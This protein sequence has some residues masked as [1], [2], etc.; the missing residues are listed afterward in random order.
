MCMEPLTDALRETLDVFEGDG[1]PLTTSEVADRLELGRRSTYERLD[2]LSATDHLETKKVGASARVWW[3]P[4]GTSPGGPGTGFD[5]TSVIDNVLDGSGIGVVVLDE[6]Y[7]VA[8]VNETIERY[9]GIDAG[10]IVGRHKPDVVRSQILDR[11]A[12]PDEFAERVLPVYDGADTGLTFDC[13][14]TGVKGEGDRWLEHR[15]RPIESGTFAGGRIEFYQ[16]VTARYRV[17]RNQETSRAQFESFIEAVDEYA[18]F[19]LDVEGCVQSWN[20]GARRLKGYAADEVLGEHISTFYTEEDRAAG[21][22]ESNLEQARQDGSIQVEGWRRRSD[23]SRFWA[24]VTIRAVETDGEHSGYIKITKDTTERR[25]RERQLRRE[26]DLTHELLETAPVRLGIYRADGTLERV[27][28]MTRRRVGL[29]AESVAEFDVDDLEFYDADGEPLSTADHPVPQVLE[30]GEPAET[31]VQHDDPDGRRHWVRLSARPVFG[32]DD[33]LERVIIAGEEVTDLKE[34]EAQL[35]RQRD[36]LS[37]ELDE[38][39]ER[40]DEAFVALDDDWRFT[41]VNEAAEGLLEESAGA[42]MGQ[43]IWERFPAAHGTRFEQE[44]RRARETGESVTFEEYFAPLETWFEVSA[45]PSENGLSVYFQ[46]V[47]ERKRREEELERYETIVETMSD[48]VYVIDDD[49]TITM[50]NES[51]AELLGYAPDEVLG[52]NAADIVDADV[53]AEARRLHEELAAGECGTARLEAELTTN[54]GNEIIAEATFGLIDTGTDGHE[55]VGVVRD[56]TQRKAREQR[57]EQYETIVETI[58]DGIYAVDGA[59]RFTL[60]NHGFVRL[61]G[62]DRAE[63]LG[64][65]ASKVQEDNITV[66]AESQ[67]REIAAGEREVG[68]VEVDVVTKDGDTVPCETRF[69]LVESAPEG[70]RCG[71]VRDI[72]DRLEQEREL[73]RRLTQQEMVAELGQRALDDSDVDTLMAEATRMVADVLDTDYCKVLELAD[74]GETLR[75]RQGVGWADGVVGSAEISA[76]DDESQAAYTLGVDDPVVVEDLTA[77]DRFSGP[78]LLTDHD[79][80][81]GISTVI[82]SASDPWGILGAHDTEV[83]SLSETDVKFVQSVANVLAAARNRHED[84]AALRRHREQLAALDSLNAVV[85]ET[86]KAAIEQPT[87]DQIESVVCENLARADSYEFAWVGVPDLSTDTVTVRTA[88]GAD[89]YLEDITVTADPED[90]RGQ[91]PT[92]RALRTGEMQVC[93]DLVESER[94]RPWRDRVAAT[95]VRSS[96]AIP[97]T[98][99]QNVYG[100]LNVYSARPDAFEAAEQDVV[101]QL[102]EMVGHAIAA[103][104]RKRALIGDEVVELEFVVRDLFE[105][106]PGV[107]APAGTIEIEQ[108]VLVGGGRVHHLRDGVI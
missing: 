47:T 54:D 26:R 56:V 94:H 22:P 75:L 66:E 108:S 11:V 12:N 3:R 4:P 28:S 32:A 98:Q 46:D 82:G 41:Y 45:Y 105:G 93:R 85:R 5:A 7:D 24:N 76:L 13:H 2:R 68:S 79:V 50:A 101:S 89:D 78:D 59:G 19:R 62:F 65:H 81:S 10:E 31:V 48:G 106:I 49:G 73:E 1:T 30:T 95:E 39:F 33:E 86:T 57:L 42:L 20:A 27:N 55:R 9:F 74:S 6:S 61:T 38:M 100:V 103:T 84:E 16:D 15:S 64:A 104:E 8:W 77:E 58:D 52:M 107:T 60:V 71:V 97:L 25:E 29:D 90:P 92:G 87:R 80:R 44:Y 21:V 53:S 72:S 36:E 51:Y 99:G 69:T 67:A 40:I 23:G 96:A 70:G 63:L 37:A 14:V 91:G 18:I 102:G 88:S 17:E 34:Q 83:R 43:R 35:E